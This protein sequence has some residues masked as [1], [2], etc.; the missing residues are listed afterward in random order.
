MKKRFAILILPLV[1]LFVSL[2]CVS[3]DVTA[4]APDDGYVDVM[5]TMAMQRL[6]AEA[7]QQAVGISYTG[8][9]AII[10]ST[11]MAEGTQMAMAVV[12]QARKDAQATD[13]R[14]R[15]DIAATE[16]RRRDD[17]AATQ[18]VQSS[19]STA[20]MQQRQVSWTA[21][22]E[23]QNMWNQATM[24]AWPV[25]DAWTQQAVVFDQQMATNEVAM[26]EL[27]VEQQRQ[28]NTPEWTIPFLIAIALTGAG[29]LYLVRYSRVREIRNGDGDVENIV[30][31]TKNIFSLPLMPGPVAV[32]I[33]TPTPSVPLL[34][35]EANQV[36]IVKRNQGIKA[37][38]ALPQA[39]PTRDAAVDLYNSM[40]GEASANSSRF[41]VL[42]PGEFPPAQLVDEQTLKSLEN[43]WKQI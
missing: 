26:K 34:T 4:V 42:H 15:Q 23:I 31:D 33:D 3:G 35:D 24:T 43:D 13:A 11:Q 10:A 41:E 25:H 38:Q 18:Y 30:V 8:T 12:E 28:K 29:V 7:T 32:D 37:L 17:V 19:I 16:Q 9:A 21:T 1:F 27:E 36:E 14:Y 6:D 2:A 40:F 20:E 5:A 39:V 22:A